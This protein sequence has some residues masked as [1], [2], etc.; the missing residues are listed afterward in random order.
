MEK[1]RFSISSLMFGTFIVGCGWMLYV[2]AEQIGGIAYMMIGLSAILIGLILPGKFADTGNSDLAILIFLAPMLSLSHQTAWIIGVSGFICLIAIVR[3][4]WTRRRM[5]HLLAQMWHL[6]DQ[7]GFTVGQIQQVAIAANKSADYPE[8]NW[9]LTRAEHPHFY[10]NAKAVRAIV[11]AMQV[12]R[13][14]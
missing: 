12:G 6:V 14:V 4:V 11:D 7:Y 8:A 10:P 5:Q 3:T 1:L 13:M 2:Y 9:L